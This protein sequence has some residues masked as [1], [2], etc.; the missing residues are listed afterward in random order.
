MEQLGLNGVF[1][2]TGIPAP[3][4]HLQIP[5]NLLMRHVV[6]KNLAIIGTVNADRTAFEHAIHDLGEFQKRWPKAIAQVISARHPV[7]NFRELLTGKA[8]GIKNVISFA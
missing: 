7:A 1:I 3:E 2:F 8:T 6:L 5:G 4:G